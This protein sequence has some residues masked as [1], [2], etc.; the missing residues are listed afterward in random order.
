MFLLKVQQ[1]MLGKRSS[2]IQQLVLDMWND[3]TEAFT[4]IY[5]LTVDDTYNYCRH[6]L[7][8]DDRS[9]EAVREIYS[10]VVKN[11]L[12][13]KDPSLFDAWLRRIAFDVC[14]DRVMA[15]GRTDLYSLLHPEEIESLSFFERE[16]FFL[17]DFVG[18]SDKDIANA[19]HITKRHVEKSLTN[20]REHILELRKLIR[21]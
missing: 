20:S 6:I 12:K 2:R 11:I 14:Y 4:E 3:D 1:M 16:I 5:C 9:L 7:G 15:E 18:L 17:H 19:L 10:I 13:L 8:E 21:A